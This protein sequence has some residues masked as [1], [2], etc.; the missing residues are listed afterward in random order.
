MVAAAARYFSYGIMRDV[1]EKVDF[2]L[3]FN[4]FRKDVEWF[5]KGKS[6]NLFFGMMETETKTHVILNIREDSV[7]TKRP[8]PWAHMKPE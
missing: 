6:L 1:T 7:K 4:E 2:E 3:H 5:E 8:S